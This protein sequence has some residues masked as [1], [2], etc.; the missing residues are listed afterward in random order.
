MTPD[1]KKTKTLVLACGIASVLLFSAGCSQK[2]P[3]EIVRQRAGERWDLLAQRKALK[4]YEY[5]SPGYRTTHTLEQYV[6]F[7]A[8]ARLQWKSA[9]VDSVKCE[10][11]VCTAKLTVV[12]TLPS[13][14]LKLQKDVDYPSPVTEKWI[15]SD[16]Q[17][18]FLPDSIGAGQGLAGPKLSA[19][20]PSAMPPM[21][22]API[23][24]AAAPAPSADND[25][26]SKKNN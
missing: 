13:A 20:N 6:A 25:D 24:S 22:A 2:D 4:A 19:E 11:D 10:E 9:T 7:V 18:Y 5:L 23:D 12:A 21:A 17:W 1:M 16:G 15:R 26:K 3:V 8:T 14:L